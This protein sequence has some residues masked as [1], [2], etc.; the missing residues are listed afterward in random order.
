MPTRHA[1]DR[2]L[3]NRLAS[4]ETPA[5]R[6]PQDDVFLRAIKDI[7]HPEERPEGAS[8]RTQDGYRIVDLAVGT[9]RVTTIFERSRQSGTLGASWFFQWSLS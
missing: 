9:M 5:A 3:E 1:G 7:R 2:W 8:R 6:A 4:F